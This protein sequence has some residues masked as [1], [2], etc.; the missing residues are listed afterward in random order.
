VT[1]FFND[2]LAPILAIVIGAFLIHKFAMVGIGRLV[3]RVI[4]GH[5]FLTPKAEKQREDT[6]ISTLGT[7]LQIS[8][9][10]I[11]TL[12]LL[13]ELGLDIAPLLAGAGIAGV[14][15]GFGAQSLVKD[16]LAGLF[17]ILENQYR[18]DD[19]V[20]INQGVAGVVT[21]ISLRQTVLRDLDGMVHHIPNGNIEIA[22]NLTMEYANVNLDIGVSYATDLEKLEKIINKV[23]RDLA[24]D[25]EWKDVIFEAPQFLRVDNFA[26]SAIIVKILGKTAPIKQW[27]VT[28]ELR[29]RLKIAFDKEGIEIPFPQ[30]T[31][32]QS[33]K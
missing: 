20:Q 6:L 13:A 7:A 26:D 4:K 17:I 28:G 22:T 11:A 5:K 8:I 21:R 33:K 12:M 19:V 25:A 3:R 15:L 24:D 9:L 23:G 29:K 10:I 27:D 16:I 32:H 14:A 1:N 2:H 31:V 30:I 18:V